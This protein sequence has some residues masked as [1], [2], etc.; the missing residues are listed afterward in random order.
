MHP[1]IW[2]SHRGY[3]QHATEN[4]AESFRA[5]RALGFEHLETDLR[6]TADGHIVL[7]HDPDLA[8]LG[9]QSL[10]IEQSPRATLEKIRLQGG[11]RLLFLDEFLTEFSGQQWIFDIKP[12]S[13]LRTLQALQSWWQQAEHAEFFK[14][15]VRFLFWNPQHQQYLLQQQPQARCMA[16]LPQCRRAAFA[17]LLA[18]PA[19]AALKNNVTYALPPRFARLN[20]MQPA[21]L[22][23]YRSRGA[24]VLA[25]LPETEADTLSALQ[26]GVDEI[27]TNGRPL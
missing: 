10:T 11:E 20:L 13:A 19:A 4:T 5:A 15:N 14:F 12:Q 21:I 7:A 17:C 3:C 26:A 25:Y 18:L 16:Q 27:L 24:K 9:G 23:R 1:P 6:T 8:R 22:A 2:I